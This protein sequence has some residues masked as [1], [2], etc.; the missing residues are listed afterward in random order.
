M[1]RAIRFILVVGDNEEW[2]SHAPSR[3]KI[4]GRTEKW[5]HVWVVTQAVRIRN[6]APTACL[7]RQAR[8]ISSRYKGR[9]PHLV[10]RSLQVCLRRERNAPR[11]RDQDIG[12][13][14]K[15]VRT[16]GIVVAA[17]FANVRCEPPLQ[18]IIG[19]LDERI[20]YC[21]KSGFTL[22]SIVSSMVTALPEKRLA[23]QLGTDAARE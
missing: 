22:R 6:A 12:R 4:S 13:W 14:R 2:P 1:R 17:K 5:S 10:A 15:R 11:A 20:P 8:A 3:G 18:A 16:V 7:G 23:Y 9:N 21:A 19:F